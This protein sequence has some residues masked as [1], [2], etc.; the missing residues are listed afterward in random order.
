M[1]SDENVAVEYI[2]ISL[3]YTVDYGFHPSVIN[4]CTH[5]AGTPLAPFL[6]WSWNSSTFGSGSVDW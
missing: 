1:I 3:Q 4:L 5:P 2:H 6:D